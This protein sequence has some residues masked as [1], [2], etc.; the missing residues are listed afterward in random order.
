MTVWHIYDTERNYVGTAESHEAAREKLKGDGI[1]VNA[2]AHKRGHLTVYSGNNEWIYEDTGESIRVPRP[3]KRC[4]CFPT[5]EGHDACLGHI[6]GAIGACCGHGMESGYVGF[7]NEF[8]YPL[9]EKGGV[10][11]T[12]W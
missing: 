3:C 9:D 4:K 1:L 7:G 10:D 6:P 11:E 5:A 2:R 8:W 12:S